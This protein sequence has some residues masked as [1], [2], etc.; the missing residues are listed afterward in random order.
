[1]KTTNMT[2]EPVTA[3]NETGYVDAPRLL[4][5][6]FPNP[7]C[8]PSIRW[9]RDQQAARKIPSVKIGRLVF[10]DPNLVK[11]YLDAKMRKDA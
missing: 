7:V 3:T 8:R 1:M 5:I 9:L 4:E 11:S 6:L 2:N 10:F